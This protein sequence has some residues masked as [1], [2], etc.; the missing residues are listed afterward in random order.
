MNGICKGTTRCDPPPADECLSITTLRSYDAAGTCSESGA[1]SYAHEDTRCKFGC[2]NGKC[3]TL[4]V[5]E[6]VLSTCALDSGGVK[7]W[8][9]NGYEDL[10]SATFI[11]SFSSTPVDVTGLT[12]GVTD[13]SD[14]GGYEGC[15]L[16]NAGGVDCWGWQAYGDMRGPWNVKGLPAVASVAGGDVWNCAVTTAGAAMCWLIGYPDG[17][18]YGYPYDVPAVVPGLQS[19]VASISASGYS[20]CAVTTAG[21]VKCWGENSSGGVT[22]PVDIVGLTLGVTQVATGAYSACAVLVEGGVRCWGIDSY[23]VLGNG[24]APLDGAPVD[25]Y[26]LYSGVVCV[27]VGTFHACALTTAGAVKCWGYNRT[28]QLGNGTTTDSNVPVDVVGLS[29]GV[30]SISAGSLATCAVM[31]AGGIKCWGDNEFGQLGVTGMVNST[32]PIDVPGY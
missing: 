17:A 29:S 18:D 13:L 32:V 21:G 31:A 24:D 20:P 12:S 16:T 6:G 9:F 7:C 23:G 22:N 25:V 19:G 15:A 11:G 26:G 1:C 30:I 14:T 10:G 4:S 2:G 27:S 5:S 3:S 28:G 8:G